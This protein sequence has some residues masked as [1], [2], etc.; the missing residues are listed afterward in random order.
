[1][2]KDQMMFYHTSKNVKVLQKE[3]SFNHLEDSYQTTLHFFFQV[4][5]LKESRQAT[6]I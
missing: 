5:Y 6:T 2:N 1:M 3:V 4:A